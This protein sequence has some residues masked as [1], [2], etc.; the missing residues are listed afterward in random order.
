[1]DALIAV[2]GIIL[3]ILGLLGTILTV[4]T[5]VNPKLRVNYYLQKYNK[6]EEVHLNL[7]GG[8]SLWRFKPHPEFTIEQQDD[9]EEWDFGVTESWMKYPLPDPSK[10]TYMVHVKAGS[11][12]IYA[13]KFITL[14]GGRYFVPL[15]RVKYHEQKKDNEYFYV[16]LQVRIARIIGTYYRMDSIDEFIKHNEIEIRDNE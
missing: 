3:G 4:I 8:N 12:V 9:S 13:E 16:P 7:G 5:F 1:M 15:P 2:L 14:D 6:W 10:H 11:T